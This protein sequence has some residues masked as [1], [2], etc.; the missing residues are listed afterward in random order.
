MEDVRTLTR[1]CID[2][3]CYCDWRLSIDGCVNSSGLRIIYLIM[4]IFSAVVALLSFSIFLHRFIFKG[5]RLFDFNSASVL[6][7]K[8]LDCLMFFLTIFNL[9][10]M[11]TGIILVTNISQTNLLARSFLFEFAWQWGYG[12]CALYLLGI[13]QTLA[14]SHKS[15]ARQWLPS[16][17]TVDIIG[18]TLLF[19]PVITNNIC[20]IAAGVIGSKGTETTTSL[21]PM[22]PSSLSAVHTAEIFVR[23]LYLFWFIHCGSLAIAVLYTGIRLLRVLNDHLKKFK[24]GVLQ[25]QKIQAGAL[26]IQILVA[27]IFLAV[28]GFAIFL[29]LYGILRDQIMQSVPGSYALCV[30]WNFLAPLASVLICLAIISNPRIDEKPALGLPNSSTGGN[31]SSSNQNSANIYSTTSNTEASEFPVN[32]SATAFETLQQIKDEMVVSGNGTYPF[33]SFDCQQ[34]HSYYTTNDDDDDDIYD[35]DDDHHHNGVRLQLS[36]SNLITPPPPTATSS[37]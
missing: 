2:G 19:A 31:A 34:N 13:A 15:T 3:T 30:L 5:H 7:P 24:P 21:D 18:L 36:K 22:T 26:K 8:P 37:Y 25:R 23:L 20:S 35:D 4:I 28:G 11:L 14:D 9:L 1:H 17:R 6:K 27:L 29:L 32:L 33:A 12:A 10:R 16:T